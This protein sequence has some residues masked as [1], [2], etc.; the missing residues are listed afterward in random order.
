LHN[1]AD[2]PA[3]VFGAFLAKNRNNAAAVA[4]PIFLATIPAHGTVELDDL[5][6]ALGNPEK[7]GGLYLLAEAA[8]AGEPLPFLHVTSYTSTPNGAGQGAYGQG[9]PAVASHHA[10]KTVAPGIFQSDQ[11]RTNVGVLN[12]SSHWIELGITLLNASNTVTTTTSWLLA[13]YEQRQTSLT[14]FGISSMEG[15]TAV[16][17][18]TSPDGTY[19]AYLSVVDQDTGDAVY[20]PAQ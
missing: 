11:R 3:D 4:S 13:P 7:T 6:S 17:V 12:T 10:V 15:G 19:C 5:V 20:L 14:S 16:F 1:A 8:G 9:I 2:E 18:Q